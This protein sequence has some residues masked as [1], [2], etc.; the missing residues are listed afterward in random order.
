VELTDRSCSLEELLRRPGITYA[1]IARAT[2]IRGSANAAGGWLGRSVPPDVAEQVELAIKYS[3]Y[4]ERQQEQVARSAAMEETPIPESID[5]NTIRSLSREAA[6]KLSRVRP[7]TLGQAS[8]VPGITPADT[9]VL[10][11]YLKYLR[12]ASSDRSSNPA[13]E[14]P[15]QAIQV[16]RNIA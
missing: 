6:E 12:A 8:R 2:A 1:D 13:L 4:I 14:T 9:A 16:Q 15:D 7:R 5:Y 11:V 3:G 10:A